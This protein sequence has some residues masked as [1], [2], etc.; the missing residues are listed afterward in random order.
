MKPNFLTI[1][2]D[3]GAEVL[4]GLASPIHIRIL[5]LLHRRG[6]LNVNEISRELALPQSTVATNIQVLEEASLIATEASAKS[7]KAAGNS[8]MSGSVNEDLTKGSA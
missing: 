6:P 8:F 1:G 5:R 4:K 7:S 3:D 2:P